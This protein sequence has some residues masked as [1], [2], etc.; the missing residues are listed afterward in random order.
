LLH[1]RLGPLTGWA[2]ADLDGDSRPDFAR[3]GKFHAEGRHL[4]QQ[5]SFCFSGAQPRTITVRTSSVAARIIVRDVDGDLDHDL[6]LETLTREPIAVLLNDGDGHF[7]EGDLEAYRSR[8]TSD[9]HSFETLAPPAPVL[10][11]SDAPSHHALAAHFLAGAGITFSH[12]RAPYTRNETQT[13]ETP[14]LTRGPPTRA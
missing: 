13:P 7:H 6:I 8:L 5:I 3:A 4:V 2:A 12:T 11:I 14:A 1:A 10:N 9:Q